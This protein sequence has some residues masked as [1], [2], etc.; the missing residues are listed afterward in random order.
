VNSNERID[1]N[2]NA[3]YACLNDVLRQAF[4]RKYARVKMQ[5]K[6]TDGLHGKVKKRLFYATTTA[7]INK[8][9]LANNY[10]QFFVEIYVPLLVDVLHY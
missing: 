7:M 9:F 1:Y 5:L 4:I 6:Y 10:R 2:K 3:I 8:N